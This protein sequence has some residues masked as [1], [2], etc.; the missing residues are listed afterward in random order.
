MLDFIEK[1]KVKKIIYHKWTLVFLCFVVV[2]SLYSTYNIWHKMKESSV[3]LNQ[4][5]SRLNTL[6]MRENEIK[7]QI[8]NMSTPLGKEAEIRSKFNVAKDSENVVVILNEEPTSSPPMH[9]K[10]V[11]Q[12][13][14]DFFR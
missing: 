12:R 1:R 13:I 7:T 6:K 14:V 8:S 2:Y 11:W 4:A 5:E 10:S 3:L 9:S